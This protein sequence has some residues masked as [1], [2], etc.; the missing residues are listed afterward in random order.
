M[1]KLAG[2]WQPYLAEIVRALRITQHVETI[3]Y[4]PGDARVVLDRATTCI[5]IDGV[6]CAALAE[7][8]FRLLE[9]L[10]TRG[11]PHVHTKDVADF[12]AKGR[13][14]EDTT[15]RAIETFV[16]AVRKAFK[17]AKP[18]APKDLAAFITMPKHG[19]YALTV[20]GFVD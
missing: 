3:V 8:H 6:L 18:R 5:W 9:V 4:A 10:M 2:A 7:L 19:Y 17:A 14:H 15:R 13:A 1:P 16:P 11:T 12:V 20:K